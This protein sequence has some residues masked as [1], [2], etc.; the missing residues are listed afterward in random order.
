MIVCIGKGDVVCHMYEEYREPSEPAVE[1]IDSTTQLKQKIK[2]GISVESNKICVENN[3]IT[4]TVILIGLSRAL[5]FILP[6]VIENF[7]LSMYKKFKKYK[8]YI[9]FLVSPS[10]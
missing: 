7:S 1:K 2:P 5:H 4:T 3:T 9:Y 6:F 8:K 10:F